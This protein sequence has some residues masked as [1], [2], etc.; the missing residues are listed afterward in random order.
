MTPN[1]VK[2]LQEL[3]YTASRNQEIPAGQA[4]YEQCHSPLAPR[5]CFEEATQ[6]ALDQ[7][8]VAFAN[9]GFIQGHEVYL[10][11][12]ASHIDLPDS[13]P[14]M[15]LKRL[16]LSDTFCT[17]VWQTQSS[18]VIIDT[19]QSNVSSHWL[20]KRYGIRSYLGVPLLTSQGLFIGV[21]EVMGDQ[22]RE[23]SKM[24]ISGLEMIARWCMRELEFSSQGAD[25]KV[26]M[27]WNARAQESLQGFEAFPSPPV[28]DFTTSVNVAKFKLL[29]KL[30]QSLKTP[31]T[32]V[33]GMT[34]VLRQQVHGNL[35]L[36]QRKYLDIVY[37]SGQDLLA[38]VNEIVEISQIEQPESASTPSSIDVE[39][40][41]E[42]SI[43]SV[44]TKALQREQEL[45]LTVEE[46]ARIWLFD[47]DRVRQSIYNLI[48]GVTEG[49]SSGS[50]ISIHVARRDE[51]MRV[52][53][54][55]SHPWLG[56][57]LRQTDFVNHE[58]FRC[59]D[60]FQPMDSDWVD[61]PSSKSLLREAAMDQILSEN[62][63][64]Q[65]VLRILLSQKLA[66]ALGGQLTLQGA[67]ESG[68]RF[69]LVLP[70]ASFP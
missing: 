39:L 58:A 59:S 8:D 12:M 25:P 69:V 15:P 22:P 70:P 60:P 46:G 63:L 53:V 20:V 64:S 19:Y 24:E 47:R 28:M 16:P 36:K 41:C 66:A 21:L 42:Q 31:L 26:L 32:P 56:D 44:K 27:Q 43:S 65:E 54:W 23:F 5:N 14:F 30:T 62:N 40:L 35:T 9:I 33:V 61:G 4:F 48:S 67:A 34:S 51:Y 11:A 7:I 17:S 45:R 6:S 10:Q 52:V 50:T 2:M 29:T 55:A 57:G 68:Y 49:A 38:L 1:L 18:D 37:Q 3:N 13:H